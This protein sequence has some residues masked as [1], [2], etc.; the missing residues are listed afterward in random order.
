MAVFQCKMCGGA[1]DINEGQNIAICPYCGSKQTIPKLDNDKV[2]KILERAN[3]LRLNGDYDKAIDEYQKIFDVNDVVD[4][5][6]YW[7]VVLCKYGVVYVDDVATGKKV[8]T[9]NRTQMTSVL[10]DEDYQKTIELADPT[11]RQL[12]EEE[13]RKI[14]D[15]QQGI[16][17]ISRNEEPFDVFICY[18]ETDDQG[19]RTRDSLLAN[20]I[21]HY[22]TDEGYKVFFS[23]ITLEDKVGKYEP[24]IFAALNSAKIMIV[25][26]S[27]KEFFESPWV[28]NEWMRYINIMK[29]DQGRSQRNLIPCYKDM[30]PYDLPRE[31]S[32]YQAQDMNK[33]GFIPDLIRG[34]KK[35]IPK[36]NFQGQNIDPYMNQGMPAGM[37]GGGNQS[38]VSVIKKAKIFIEQRDY[39]SAKRNLSVAFDIDPENWEIY[40]CNLL[41]DYNLGN[42][43]DLRNLSNTFDNNYNYR[44]ILQYADEPIA[45]RIKSYND[46]IIERLAEQNAGLLY[47]NANDLAQ[48]K[49]DNDKLADARNLY[50]RIKN[51]KDSE[52]KARKCT[53]LIYSNIMNDLDRSEDIAK[54]EK[55]KNDISYIVSQMDT[56]KIE[57]DLSKKIIYLKAKGVKNNAFASIQSVDE[58]IRALND[59]RDFE[60]VS[61]LIYELETKKINIDR[62]L[63]RAKRV[64]FLT[65]FAAAF[66]VLVL[67]MSSLIIGTFVSNG[68]SKIKINNASDP[69]N[70]RSIY[71]YR[72]SGKIMESGTVEGKYSILNGVVA[73]DAW[74]KSGDKFYYYD[75]D[76]VQVRDKIVT[77]DG[78]NYAFDANGASIQNDFY[79]G[80]FFGPTGQLIVNDVAEIDGKMYYLN[81]DGEKARDSKYPCNSDFALIGEQVINGNE[82]DLGDDGA[83]I[84]SSWKQKG[85]RYVY[86]DEVG[87][88][89]KGNRKIITGDDGFAKEYYFDADG[90]LVTNQ[91]VEGIYWAKADGSF[92]KNEVVDI[93]GKK[94]FYTESGARAN[95]DS[96]AGGRHLVNGALA[97]GQQP[98]GYLY[99]D[100]VRFNGVYNNQFYIDG[101]V[102]IQRNKWSGDFYL[103][104]N[105]MP[106]TNAWTPDGYYVGTDGRYLRSTEMNIGG[107][108]Y[109]FD[110]NGKSTIKQ[111]PGGGGLVD[112]GG[113]GYTTIE[114]GTGSAGKFRVRMSGGNSTNEGSCKIT[115]KVID[116]ISTGSSDD[117][118]EEK[119]ELM[120]DPDVRH[121]I[122]E[123]AIDYCKS[124]ADEFTR[125]DIKKYEIQ[126]VSG[127]T[128]NVVATIDGEKANGGKAN[129]K[130]L[131]MSLNIQNG[132]C[133]IEKEAF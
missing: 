18:K 120:N 44:K 117:D 116:D 22:L 25:I 6:I 24:Y 56:Q 34:I 99:K 95:T 76:G 111:T 124:V 46:Y 21:Y 20:E 30:D 40:L 118:L 41:M 28:K 69:N 83:K 84:T 14:D 85:N 26:G 113:G 114:D 55:A 53:E 80:K 130:K 65:A 102:E 60:G 51:H 115:Y 109:I 123:T 132:E 10:L 8:P 122:E 110:A 92:A 81:I 33:L 35:I 74:F 5:E 97:E 82:Y 9:V 78:K 2:N 42:E 106:M 23:R 38:V 16:L 39:E 121:S 48:F 105:G 104:S 7:N 90:F 101:K 68:L 3:T 108:T 17:A 73:K 98:D 126:T 43:N 75:N 71:V 59:I 128:A 86:Y 19:N 87:V 66:V 12:Y 37:Q 125:L 64:T 67:V 1:L 127:N 79:G 119:A 54:L 96:E 88:K 11:T 100:G 29:K 50:L 47:N 49:T 4:A 36:N 131:R 13:A 112:T 77:I 89:V 129:N 91:V 58:S 70:G 27:K 94:Y 15:I 45:N 32:Y 133:R 62:N 31:F 107:K 93:G 57:E 52:E 72:I 63:K 103:G 61:E